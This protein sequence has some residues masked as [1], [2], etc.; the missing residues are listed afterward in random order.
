MTSSITDQKQTELLIFTDLDGT[1]LDSSYSHEMALPAL[2]LVRKENI[3]L[4]ICSSKTRVEIEVIRNRLGN[5]YP[6]VSENGGG[7]YLPKNT[8]FS[9]QICSANL[10]CGDFANTKLKI[11]ETDEYYLIKLGADYADLRRALIEIR[12][13]GFDVRGFGDMPPDEV[14][15]LTGL[16]LSDAGLAKKRD[17]DETF[18][19]RGDE[20]LVEQL[21]KKIIQKGF[22]YTQ[23]NISM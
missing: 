18:V 12:D 23:G 21:K 13:E 9:P 17:F 5:V 16:K 8:K 15:E 10:R 4:I 7:I 14:A 19:F 3:P 20:S 11:E 6:F 1:L 22:N 2:K